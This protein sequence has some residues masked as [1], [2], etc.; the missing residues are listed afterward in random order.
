MKNNPHFAFFGTSEVSVHV[1]ETLKEAGYVPNL[2]VTMPDK[3]KGRKF[4]ITPPE[5]KTWGEENG[6]KVLQ[7][8]KLDEAFIHDLK[9]ESWDL[10]IVVAYGKIMPKTLLDIP[11]HKSINVHYSLLPKFR[12]S[13]PVEGAIL[14]DDK[15]TGVTL[16]QMDEAMD[17]GPIIAQEKVNLTE[18]PLKRCDLMTAL[19]EVG[20]KLLV[21]TLPIWL[22]G[23]IIPT[24]QD[25]TQA[26]FVKMIKKEN[27][28]LDLTDDEYTNYRK[29]MAYETWPRAYFL[30]DGKRVIINA[31]EWKDGKLRILRVTPEGRK[32]MNYSDLN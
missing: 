26:T 11:I 25:H 15:E 6:I 29:I 24:E 32:E 5:V 2:I 23:K 19:N 18:W 27:A 8:E 10:F 31:A 4:V 13:S 14:A 1:L 20:G 9:K 3:P 17:H 7:P 30:K 28:L 22:E 16:I 21:E 12:G